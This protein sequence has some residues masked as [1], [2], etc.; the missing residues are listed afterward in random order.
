MLIVK[1]LYL[2]Q[3][4]SLA[5][6]SRAVPPDATKNYAALGIALMVLPPPLVVYQPLVSYW[7]RM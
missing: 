4:P 3:L 6:N 5:Q 2:Y 1:D 7:E